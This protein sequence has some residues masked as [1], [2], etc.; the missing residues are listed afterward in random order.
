MTD[1]LCGAFRR[2]EAGKA[3]GLV[4]HHVPYGRTTGERGDPFAA[5]VKWT[6]KGVRG[7]SHPFQDEGKM[8]GNGLS[9][10]VER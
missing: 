3:T 8:A 9:D 7:F 4:I 5:R 10:F 6:I 2:E 1:R